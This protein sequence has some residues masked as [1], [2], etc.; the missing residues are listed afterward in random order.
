V[1]PLFRDQ[2]R[3]G[4]PITVTHPDMT[5]YFMTIPEASQLVLQAGILG[6]TGKVFVL[7]MGA[8]V[9]IVDMAADMARLSGLAP[10][11]D[12]DIKFT[13]VRPGEKL[14][15]ELF[16]ESEQRESGVHSKV[17]EAVQQPKEP[18]FL[19][20][21]LHLLQAAI[22]LPEGSRQR[23]ML[24]CFQRLV[25]SYQPSMIGLGSYAIE[26]GESTAVDAEEVPL[27]N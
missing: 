9:R 17:F 13:G 2:I 8:P 1:I 26:A 10:G 27:F 7:D 24:R 12:I 6:Q 4:G 20:Q 15:E 16:T 14:F 18:Q 5:R 19:N 3:K 11:I 21:S 23:E 22:T 25:P